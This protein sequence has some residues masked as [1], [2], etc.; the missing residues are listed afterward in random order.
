MK[1]FLV[2]LL[3]FSQMT[4]SMEEVEGESLLIEE[5]SSSYE[6]VV[7]VKY[8]EWTQFKK[9]GKIDLYQMLG[10]LKGK[11]VEKLVSVHNK[12]NKEICILSKIVSSTNAKGFFYNEGK[13]IV[14]P[15]QIV[16]LGGYRAENTQK[17]WRV[18]WEYRGTQN[19]SRCQ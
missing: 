4:Y 7:D 6:E 12:Y 15:G 11:T 1:S 18:R 16:T 14:E 9:M 8:G 5:M 13:T 3:L 19:L 2:L 10:K 17:S